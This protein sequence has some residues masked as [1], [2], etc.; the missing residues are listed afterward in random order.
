[1]SDYPELYKE[2]SDYIS[3]INSLQSKDPASLAAAYWL[4]WYWVKACGEL[5]AASNK[6]DSNVFYCIMLLW[7]GPKIFI[8]ADW[9]C[10]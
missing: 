1:M 10:V 7:I 3:L 6:T 4:R 8:R 5:W 2:Y 9:Y